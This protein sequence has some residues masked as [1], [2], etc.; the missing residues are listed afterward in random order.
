MNGNDR[1]G[2]RNLAWETGPSV[3]SDDTL[4]ILKESQVSH[5]GENL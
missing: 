5:P 2:G 1:G 4:E 3:P